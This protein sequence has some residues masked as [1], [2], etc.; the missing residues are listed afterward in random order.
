MA[1]KLRELTAEE[2]AEISRLVHSRMASA[3]EVERA[4]IIN[5]APVRMPVPGYGRE[6]STLGQDGAQVAHPV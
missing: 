4:Q 1:L 5:L 2:Q 3:R 6:A